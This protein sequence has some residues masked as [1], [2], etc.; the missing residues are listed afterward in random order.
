MKTAAFLP[1]LAACA[2]SPT[3]Q[4]ASP[5]PGPAAT[6]DPPAAATSQGATGGHDS[7]TAARLLKEIS[8]WDKTA[9]L[10][11][12][13]PGHGLGKT[14]VVVD[15]KPVWPPQGPGCADLVACCN[16]FSGSGVEIDAMQL[17]CQFSVTKRADCP[18]ALTTVRSVVSEKGEQ[19]PAACRD[20]GK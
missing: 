12:A 13:K 9:V 20:Q 1:L 18:R 17:V 3:P 16:G 10:R 5:D 11:E 4:P 19:A 6:Q 15:G 8:D 2:S 14:E 7:P